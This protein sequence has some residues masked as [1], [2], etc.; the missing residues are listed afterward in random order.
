MPTGYTADIVDGKVTTFKEFAKKCIRAFGAAIHMRDDSLNKKYEP[1]EESNHHKKRLKEAYEENQKLADMS[2]EQLVKIRK[3]EI[4]EAIKYQNEQI[5]EKRII[6]ER[7]GKILEETKQ[8]KEPTPEHLNYKAFMIQ[9]IEDTIKWDGEDE[10]NQ[11]ELKKLRL[12]N[13]NI[14]PVKVRK[15]KQDSIDWD[16]EYHTKEMAK[17]TENVQNAN[18]WVQDILES[19]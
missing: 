1:R 18:K 13:S 4:K 16:I 11:E 3:E 5:E 19:I 15:S 12:E 10:Y 8:W 17:E 6:R 7:L 14:D 9:Q 2:D